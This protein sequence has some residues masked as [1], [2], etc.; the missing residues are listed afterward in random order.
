MFW[1][2]VV[3]GLVVVL[4]A[5]TL[6]ERRR[7][8]TGVAKGEDRHLNAQEKRGGVSGWGSGSGSMQ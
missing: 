3:I 7:N 5:V 8:S 2:F 1:W 6:L 4:V